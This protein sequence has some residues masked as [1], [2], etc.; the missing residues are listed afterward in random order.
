M[1][2]GLHKDQENTLNTKPNQRLQ[3]LGQILWREEEEGKAGEGH[4]G[5]QVQ[6]VQRYGGVGAHRVL[7]EQKNS[8]PTVGVRHTKRVWGYSSGGGGGHRRLQGGSTS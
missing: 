1:D 5:S 8:S 3:R 2:Q 6:H 7:E 4:L